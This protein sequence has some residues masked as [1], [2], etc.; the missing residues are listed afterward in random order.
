M[1]AV[2]NFNPQLSQELDLQ[3]DARADQQ[4]TMHALPP[5]DMYEDERLATQDLPNKAKRI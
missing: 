4:R 5:E 2:S 3:L 1:S